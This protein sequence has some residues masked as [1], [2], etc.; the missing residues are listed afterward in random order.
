MFNWL[1]D[2]FPHHDLDSSLDH[3]GHIDHADHNID[4]HTQIGE[5][6]NLSVDPNIDQ[7]L[8]APEHIQALYSLNRMTDEIDGINM[9]QIHD[10]VQDKSFDPEAYQGLI[11]NWK[12]IYGE[13][14][15]VDQLNAYSESGL[16]YYIPSSTTNPGIDIY[17]VDELGKTQEMIQ[18]KMSDDPSYIQDALTKLPE[19]AKLM[20][21]SEVAH[22]FSD[23]RII[24]AGFT[25]S[26]L[27]QEIND[28]TELINTPEDWETAVSPEFQT[29]LTDT[30]KYGE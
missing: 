21:P 9:E 17:G 29:W 20:C 23:P 26:E 8:G 16:H 7:V 30:Y 11:S 10:F 2:L 3:A 22:S 24:D 27:L 25:H 5:S 15:A 18:V 13:I 4:H 14:K 19:G 6:F 1:S 12:G 28:T